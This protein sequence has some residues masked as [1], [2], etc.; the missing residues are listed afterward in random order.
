MKVKL[1]SQHHTGLPQSLTALE[2]A[3]CKDLDTEGINDFLISSACWG[4]YCSNTNAM[5]ALETLSLSSFDR[6]VKYASE[7]CLR[8]SK[9]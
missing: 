7:F 1:F 2:N 6:T 4:I 5:N 3:V 8:D 9:Y